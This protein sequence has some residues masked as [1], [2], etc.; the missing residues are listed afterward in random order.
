MPDDH[1]HLIICITIITLIIGWNIPILSREETLDS[2]RMEELFVHYSD[3]DPLTVKL[4]TIC[5]SEN[6][7]NPKRCNVK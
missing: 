3:Y 5:Q 1:K 7:D 6:L 4:W 2:V